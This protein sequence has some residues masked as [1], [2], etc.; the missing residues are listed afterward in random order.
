MSHQHNI[1][2]HR[3]GT[4]SQKIPSAA[5]RD[6]GAGDSVKRRK[7]RTQ[8]FPPRR[9]ETSSKLAPANYVFPRNPVLRAYHA[10]SHFDI[11]KEPKGMVQ[12]S[13]EI[14]CDYKGLASG[15]KI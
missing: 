12:I 10:F 13:S 9:F 7:N 8:F 11:A 14:S 3:G 6:S 5:I 1:A 2:F 4:Q 15:A